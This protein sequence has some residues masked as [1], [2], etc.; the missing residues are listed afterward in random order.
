MRSTK[1]SIL[2]LFL[3]AACSTEEGEK[4]VG[5][6]QTDAGEC[7]AKCDPAR[8]VVEVVGDGGVPV[9]T[10]G[11]VPV[12]ACVDNQCMLR[13]GS[14]Y[15]CF[16]P[17]ESCAPAVED[18][19]RADV[20]ICQTNDRPEELLKSCP[21]GD[22]G[23][24]DDECPEDM[25][26]IVEREG[27]ADAY[28]TEPDCLTDADCAPGMYCGAVRD[29]HQICGTS[30]GDNIFCGQTSE[31]CIEPEDLSEDG[32]LFEGPLCVMRRACL[33]R[34]E[35]A[36][37]ETDVDC[38]F[39]STKCIEID[40]E[41]RCASGCDFDSDCALD[42]ECE[43]DF[44][45]PRSGSCPAPGGRFCD[46]CLSDMDCGDADNMWVCDEVQI[47]QWV[48][49]DYGTTCGTSAECETTPRGDQGICWWAESYQGTG[50]IPICHPGQDPDSG[51]FTCW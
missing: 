5:G 8:C 7:L 44:C 1:L 14:H 49:L 19:T 10:D 42:K 21:F 23:D 26:C 33:V 30:K 31:D 6:I 34:D 40:G 38:S 9:L 32:P 48:C 4:C 12:N 29:P 51:F 22:T 41:M 27:D 39:S 25:L 46:P 20:N 28:C 16:V 15:D 3:V 24:Y 45:I 2:A 47:G 18:D 43:D 50:A 17:T 13:C 37:C 35:C 11:G 36:P